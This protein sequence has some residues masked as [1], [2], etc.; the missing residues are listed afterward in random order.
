MHREQ[1]NFCRDAA[2]ET[3]HSKD[4]TSIAFDCRGD[5]PPI[6]V[7]SGS[8]GVRSAPV[9]KQL[10]SSLASDFTVFTYDRRGRGDSGDTEPYAVE[11]EI[12]DIEALIDEAGGSA[13]VFGS[14][15]GA[16]LTLEAVSSKLDITKI[17]L[18][19]PPFI[20]DSS[21]PPVP[22]DYL[23][24]LNELIAAGHRDDAVEFF[25]T[26]VVGAPPETIVHMQTDP[27]W[28]EMEEVAHT[29]VY[30]GTIMEDLMLGDS[31]SSERWSAATVPTLVINGEESPEFLQHAA[32]EL[33]DVLHEASHRTLEDQAHD[34]D[35]ASLAPV[36]K[37]FFKA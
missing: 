36:L 26:E 15:S 11:R 13:F 21:R 31:L 37:E 30:D 9:V 34:A 19:E 6:I 33:V 24:R 8:F 35:P 17:A 27:S 10:A 1:K 3:V 16:V 4:G 29:L 2:M 12:E 32:E 7:V 22:E 14:S 25:M 23:D 20:V 5:G 18:Y 28:S